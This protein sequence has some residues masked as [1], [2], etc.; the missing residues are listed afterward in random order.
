VRTGAIDFMRWLP[1]LSMLLVSVISYIDRNTLAILAPT[2]LK[3]THLSSQQYGWIILAFSIA[4]TIG[5]PIWGWI[6]DRIGVRSGMAASV[7]LWTLAS[8]AHVFATG[9]ASFSLAR[10]AL[11]FGEGAT[12]PGGLRTVVQTLPPDL[13]A[14]GTAPAYSGGSLGALITPLVVTPIA[15]AWGWHG[16][17]WF[18]GAVGA[19]WLA[20]WALLSRTEILSAPQPTAPQAEMSWTDPGLWAFM[21][22]YALGSFPLGFVL[23]QASIYL[24]QVLHQPQSTIG[25]VLWIPPLGWETGYFFWGWITDRFTASGAALKPLGRLYATLT[26]LS[27]PLAAVPLLT[28]LKLTLTMLFFT[29]FICAGFLI[30][31]VAQAAALYPQRYSGL[32]AGLTSGAWSALV[33]LAMPGIGKLFDQH[34]YGTAF[35]IASLAPASGLAIWWTLMH[36]A[37]AQTPSHS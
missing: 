37:G 13:R 1:A 33:G 32:V 14:R 9:T 17:F 8:I 22:I 23:Y 36:S 12:F 26:I 20:G 30:A 7:S 25:R 35:T 27:L 4:Y 5:N 2:I 11:G 6:L 10:A 29:M 19:L 3:E 21:T 34:M 16:A 24:S 15:A 18:T 31:G 28:S